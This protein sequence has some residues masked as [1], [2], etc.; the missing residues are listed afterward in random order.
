MEQSSGADTVAFAN[1]GVDL[2][3]CLKQAQ[4]FGL[5]QTM[6]MVGLNAFITNIKSSG[7]QAAQ[8]LTVTE[9]FYW[10][11]N[12][13]TR[14]FMNRVKD[15]VANNWPNQVHASA[16]SGTLHYLKAVAELG[17]E[18]AKVSGRA[19]IET[20]KK[21]P[22]DDDAFGPG[23]IRADGRRVCPAYLFQVKKPEE[24]SNPWDVYKLLATTPAD[25]AVRPL[26][27]GGCPLTKT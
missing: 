5:T 7:L 27:E 25:E 13:R 18:R 17:A 12:D 15:A 24:S 21:I 2:D 14:A 19:V 6:R 4:E 20:M 26:A 8:G 11:L 16:Y 9:I 1:T 23:L 3:N 22:M 10:D